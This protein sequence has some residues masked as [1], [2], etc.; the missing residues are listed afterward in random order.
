MPAAEIETVS[1]ESRRKDEKRDVGA[2]RELV[3]GQFLLFGSFLVRTSE[4]VI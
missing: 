4:T 2:T 1:N 3:M